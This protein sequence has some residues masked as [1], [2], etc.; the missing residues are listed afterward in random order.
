[1]TSFC[2][3]LWST[4]QFFL[5]GGWH[6][7]SHVADNRMRLVDSGLRRIN[8]NI[9][10]QRQDQGESCSRP[11]C[12]APSKTSCMLA[13]FPSFRVSESGWRYVLTLFA[14]QIL[15]HA[16]DLWAFCTFVYK[17]WIRR[18]YQHM[19]WGRGL[20]TCLL[21]IALPT[22]LILYRSGCQCLADMVDL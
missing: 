7:G 11:R 8:P 19:L 18:P 16:G 3:R 4:F 22:F 12:R 15:Q 14:L 2:S 13:S 5:G 20:V 17:C 10:K 6:A 21:G 1:M 9:W